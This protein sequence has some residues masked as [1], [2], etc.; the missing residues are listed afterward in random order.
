MSYYYSRIIRAGFDEA[1]LKTSEALKEEGFS[2]ITE[3]NLNEKF[4]E[5]LNVNFRKYKILG[6]CNPS[7]AYQAVQIEEK[8]GVM[9]PCNVVVIDKENGM[10]E[11][12]A[13]DPVASMMAVKNSTMRPFASELKE[14]L[15][16]AIDKI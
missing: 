8:I 1:V 7:V 13:I 2:I 15:Q 3:I 10:L 12:A 14:K 9:L 11:I 16:K 4:K 5:K 6:A